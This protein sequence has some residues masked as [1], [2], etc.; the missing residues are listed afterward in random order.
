MSLPAAIHYET[1]LHVPAQASRRSL[2][3]Q[4]DPARAAVLVH[5]MQRYFL[6]PYA[7]DCPA[8]R[9]AVRE[10]ARILAAARAAGVPVFYTAQTGLSSEIVRGLQGDFWGPGMSPVPEHT[11]IVEALEPVE[12]DVVLAKHRYSAFAH[13]DLAERLAELGRD[14]LVVTGVYA[15]IGVTA[16]A[17]D[18]FMREVHPFV[19]AD[20][21]ADFGPAE[22]QRALE[23][24]ASC[25][26]VVTT[27]EVV[28]AGLAPVPPSVGEGT[29]ELTVE[30]ALGA[31]LDADALARIKAAPHDD[32]FAHGL[33]SLRAF[34]M[35]DRLADAGVD[36][37]FADFTRQPSW[38][39]L[40]DQGRMA[41]TS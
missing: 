41:V 8:L 23:Q 33:T 27:A 40:L 24:I 12:G 29:W 14:Q 39:F 19:V 30:E 6:R 25:C 37:D 5:D 13:T 28:V 15:H 2:D 3:W 26:G 1:P 21:V 7:E 20:A 17:T 10:T 34:E 36:V 22:H 32:L 35:L 11:D 31:V 9:T 38:S 16:T 4:L 18:A